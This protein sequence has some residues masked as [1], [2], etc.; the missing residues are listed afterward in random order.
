M[1]GAL[2]ALSACD[3]PVEFSKDESSNQ[4]I[5]GPGDIQDPVPVEPPPVVVPPPVEPP[6]V[7]VPPP[8]EPPPEEPPPVLPPPVEP[9]PVVVPPPVEPPPVEPP[10]PSYEKNQGACSG[11]SSTSLVSCM[12]C[13]VPQAV[14]PPPQLSRKAQELIQIMSMS[15]GVPNR[16]D[17]AGYQPPTAAELLERMQQCSPTLYPDTAYQNTEASTLEG[18]LGK[19][20]WLREKLFKRFFYYPPYTDDFA[21]Y[22]GLEIV[23][24][25]YMLCYHDGGIPGDMYPIEYIRSDDR[26]N[27][28][29]PELWINANR[30][31]RQ[32]ENCMAKSLTTPYV[33]PKPDPGYK[34]DF[35]NIKGPAGDKIKDQVKDWLKANYKV[36]FESESLGLCGQVE[37]IS[38]LPS[39]GDIKAA[40]Y[41]CQ[42]K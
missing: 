21:T 5:Q 1:L 34:C 17:P 20:A 16:S 35:E 3:N 7:V 41:Y 36:G 10:P 28:V 15:C 11:D 2:L 27:F 26:L 8:V 23:E 4:T 38:D 29:M 31:R 42:K 32:L 19:E 22:F 25:R 37:K 18:L 13:D 14:P 33:P 9:P 39:T 30:V 12:K 40:G 6:P 24:A